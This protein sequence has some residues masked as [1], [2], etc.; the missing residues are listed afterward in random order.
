[1][2]AEKL[3]RPDA[4]GRVSLGKYAKGVSSYRVSVDA[5]TGEITLK[6]YTEIQLY[7]KWLFE[8]KEALASVRRGMEQSSKGEIVY[9]GSFQKYLEEDE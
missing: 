8:N 4:K 3:L 6:P 1:M 7:E 9:L 5:P 2:K